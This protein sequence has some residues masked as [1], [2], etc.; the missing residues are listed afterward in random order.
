MVTTIKFL[1]L[2]EVQARTGKS[3]STIYQGVN[4]GTFPKPIVL[5]PKLHVWLDADIDQW[6]ASKIIE[7]DEGTGHPDEAADMARRIREAM[8]AANEKDDEDKAAKVRERAGEIPDEA[9]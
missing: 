2:P 5:G 8:G 7:R 3:R 4:D 6:W 9:A 1:K